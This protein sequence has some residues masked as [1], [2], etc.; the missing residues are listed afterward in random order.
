[1]TAKSAK[2]TAKAQNEPQPQK[3]KR[4]SMREG[5]KTPCVLEGLQEAANL[6]VGSNDEPL[7]QIVLSMEED[8][9]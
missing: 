7:D 8:A 6:I 3:R 4:T 1:M 5:C 2:G 9:I